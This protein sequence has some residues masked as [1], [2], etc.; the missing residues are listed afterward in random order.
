MDKAKLQERKAQLRAQFDQAVSNANA[1]QGALQNV[2]WM[3]A[4]IEKEAIAKDA[5]A[6]DAGVAAVQS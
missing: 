2:D 4:E 1:L 3:I 6:V 5:A